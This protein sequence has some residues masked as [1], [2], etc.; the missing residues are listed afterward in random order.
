MCILDKQ[1]AELF[2][3]V[4]DECVSG[5]TSR[6]TR[7]SIQQGSNAS[8]TSQFTSLSLSLLPYHSRFSLSLSPVF[9]FSRVSSIS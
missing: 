5:I 7:P 8:P 9:L 6:E 1:V 3:L 4:A 2:L